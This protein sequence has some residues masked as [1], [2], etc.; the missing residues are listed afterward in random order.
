MLNGLHAGPSSE[1]T[2]VGGAGTQILVAGGERSAF[3]PVMHSG[4]AGF[5]LAI[6]TGSLDLRA[7]S[8]AVVRR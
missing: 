8:L 2:F 1:A 7:A 4:Q 5:N 6:G 3:E